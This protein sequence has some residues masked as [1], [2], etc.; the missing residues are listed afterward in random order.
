MPLSFPK[1]EV[2]RDR[3]EQIPEGEFRLL[4]IMA[5]LLVFQAETIEAM[6]DYLISEARKFELTKK[7]ISAEELKA[8]GEL[9]RAYADTLAPRIPKPAEVI[10]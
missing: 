4:S 8:A 5:E 9:L 7:N 1:P 10:Q 6:A 2:L 3:I